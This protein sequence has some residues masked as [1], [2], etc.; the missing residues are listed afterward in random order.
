MT[1]TISWSSWPVRNPFL[2]GWAVRVWIASMDRPSIQTSFLSVLQF[3]RPVVTSD[4]DLLGLH[5]QREAV[6]HFQDHQIEAIEWYDWISTAIE[7]DWSSCLTADPNPSQGFGFTQPIVSHVAQIGVSIEP[8]IAISQMTADPNASVTQQNNFEEFAIKAA[9]N[10][11][12]FCASFANT[13]QH[14]ATSPFGGQQF[15][16]LSTIQQWYENFSRRLRQ[17]PQYWRNWP[18]MKPKWWT[19]NAFNAFND[20]PLSCE[21]RINY[22]VP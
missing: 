14:F 15:V 16:P 19:I 21:D 22:S 17:D 11:F 10:L 9:E 8:M 20:I 1:S 3:P 7:S 2:K 4:V 13:L 5:I 18:P 6:S 12:N